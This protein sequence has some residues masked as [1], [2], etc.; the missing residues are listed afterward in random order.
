MRKHVAQM[1]RTKDRSAVNIRRG[2]ISINL[3]AINATIYC[4]F[5]YASPT[6][7]VIETAIPTFPAPYA[8]QKQARGTDTASQILTSLRKQGR[9]PCRFS[10]VLDEYTFG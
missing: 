9:K 6:A 10:D 3:R 5:V 7:T 1:V 8:R 2:T 4:Y